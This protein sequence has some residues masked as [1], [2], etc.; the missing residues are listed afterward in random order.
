V[1]YVLV[2]SF[3]NQ[4]VPGTD[5]L[6]RLAIVTVNFSTP[7]GEP[8]RAELVAINRLR[9]TPPH[10]HLFWEGATDLAALPRL[11]SGAV[12][13]VNQTLIFTQIPVVSDPRLLGA[14]G[15]DK[16]YL[17]EMEIFAGGLMPIPEGNAICFLDAQG[18]GIFRLTQPSLPPV[19]IR[20][21][22]DAMDV[23]S[24]MGGPVT[25]SARPVD[26]YQTD[27]EALL[28]TFRAWSHGQDISTRLATDISRIHD[29]GPVVESVRPE[30]SDSNYLHWHFFDS[31]I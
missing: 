26:Q 2:A 19:S 17:Q 6:I 4:S 3:L 25:T 5:L 12:V 1:A 28:Q 21:G 22:E 29:I 16:L 24:A 31:V 11:S 8:P 15:E 7:S 23:T 27:R 13:L 10:T 9:E 20:L 18:R 30:T 14:A